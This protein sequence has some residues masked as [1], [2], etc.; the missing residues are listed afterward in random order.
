M[1]KPLQIVEIGGILDHR[2]DFGIGSHREHFQ[3][4]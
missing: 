3:L 1:N 2:S 4:K